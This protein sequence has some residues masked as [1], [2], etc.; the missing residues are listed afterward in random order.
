MGELKLK[1]AIEG[2]LES[3]GG[4]PKSCHPSEE[5]DGGDAS[6][7]KGKEEQAEVDEVRAAQEVDDDE[8]E[9]DEA[10]GGGLGLT[11]GSH[12]GGDEALTKSSL[13]PV[14]KQSPS[15][16]SAVPTSTMDSG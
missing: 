11:L 8:E 6:D 13:L 2:I 10:G 14:P 16:R 12:E 7:D 5:K 9:E 15:S 1:E 4:V 3:N